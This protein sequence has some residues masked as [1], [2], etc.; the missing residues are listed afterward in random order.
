MRGPGVDLGA[1][2]GGLPPTLPAMMPFPMPARQ[3]PPT[4]A[5]P[6]PRQPSPPLPPASLPIIHEMPTGEAA[7]DRLSDVVS[8]D[9]QSI[10]E[11]LQSVASELGGGRKRGGVKE[12]TLNEPGK[13]RGRKGV[14]PRP[15]KNVVVI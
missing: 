4:S 3:P 13:K 10:P 14:A 15:A 12:I 9:L 7:S 6:P 8:E 2:L 5:P 11:D 1:L